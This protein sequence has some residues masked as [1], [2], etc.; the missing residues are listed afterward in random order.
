M[1][2]VP[3]SLHQEL[4]RAFTERERDLTN[5]KIRVFDLGGHA[6]FQEQ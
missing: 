1:L 6:E 5:K 3:T 2:V 4:T